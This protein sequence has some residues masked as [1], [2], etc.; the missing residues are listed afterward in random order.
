VTITRRVLE[1]VRA[2]AV[3]EAPRECC[4][5]LIG[6]SDAIVESVRA[7]NLAD[8]N[9]RFLIDP[10]DHIAALRRV[11]AASLDV[12]GFY[13]SHPRSRPYPSETDVAESGY[14]GAAHLIV[15]ADGEARLFDIDGQAVR[16]RALD[17]I[18]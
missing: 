3:E 1:D 10:Q 18:A 8:G 17:V 13:H 6:T 7:R 11:R 2:H 14:A 12:I 4:G 9:S 16:E 15:G 5:M